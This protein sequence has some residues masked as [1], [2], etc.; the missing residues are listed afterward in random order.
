MRS[1]VMYLNGRPLT[2]GDNNELPCLSG[3][4]VHAGEYR[5]APG[6]CAFVVI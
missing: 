5:I 2:L 1:K 3:E 6:S 4:T